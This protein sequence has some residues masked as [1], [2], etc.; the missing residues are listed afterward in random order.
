MDYSKRF[1]DCLDALAR[2]ALQQQGLVG[3]QLD[4][5]RNMDD[6]LTVLC[7]S[8][9][10]PCHTTL[11]LLHHAGTLLPL[12][13]DAA[14]TNH[15][16]SAA[17]TQGK[18]MVSKPCLALYSQLFIHLAYLALDLGFDQFELDIL[19]SHLIEP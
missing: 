3:Q 7:V 15:R 4:S 17:H 13:V 5:P 10:M 12:R 2:D 16:L 18:R 14:H 8:F 1:L 19:Q 6:C 9:A 11:E